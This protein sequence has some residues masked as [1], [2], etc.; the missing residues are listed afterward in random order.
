M[1]YILRTKPYSDI[2]SLIRSG[3]ENALHLSELISLTGIEDRSLRKCI[4]IIRRSGK[5]IVSSDNG[6]FF[7]ADIREIDEYIA[8]ESARVTSSAITLQTAIHAREA[9]RYTD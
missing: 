3:E 2:I 9:M 1:K 7:P 5:A 4:E 8:R 6:Y